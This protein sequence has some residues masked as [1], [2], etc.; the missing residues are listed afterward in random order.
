MD[1]A[2]SACCHRTCVN[3]DDSTAC[4]VSH[5]NTV[6]EHAP[7]PITMQIIQIM[8]MFVWVTCSILSFVHHTSQVVVSS[9]SKWQLQLAAAVAPHWG[10]L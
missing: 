6:S 7:K 3:S 8:V 1:G 10:L 5:L 4:S 9:G 2:C